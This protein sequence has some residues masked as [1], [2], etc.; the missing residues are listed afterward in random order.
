MT[1]ITN[2]TILSTFSLIRA[3]VVA[4]STLSVKF[5]ASN[6]YQ[7]EPKHKSAGFKAFPYIWVNIPSSGSEKVVFDNNF[8]LREFTVTVTLRVDWQARDKVLSYCNAFIKAMNDYES[9][10]QAVGYYDPLTELLS[11]DSNVVIE[12]KEIVEAVFDITLHGQVGRA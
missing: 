12:S 6:I 10:F 2:T 5:N 8:E 3:A 9:V 7:F 4:N 11:V 1:A